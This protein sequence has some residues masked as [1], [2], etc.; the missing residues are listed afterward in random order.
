MLD[1]LKEFEFG[2]SSLN[3]MKSQKLYDDLNEVDFMNGKKKK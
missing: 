1:A 3:D 2:P